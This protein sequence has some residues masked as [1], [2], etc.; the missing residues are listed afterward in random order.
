MKK[1]IYLTA[2]LLSML[3]CAKFANAQNEGP[4]TG[5]NLNVGSENVIDDNVI[6]GNAI[7]NNNRLHTGNTF[8]FG[9]YNSID[10]FHSTNSLVFG[11]RNTLTGSNTSVFGIENLV[12]T[13]LGFVVGQNVETTAS[14]NAFVFGTGI[15]SENRL[16]NALECSFMVGFNSTR[17]TFLVYGPRNVGDV[18][19]MTGKIAIGDVSGDELRDTD[20]KMI[21]RSDEGEDAG[22]ILEPKQP[23]TNGTFIRLHDGNHGISVGTNGEMCISSGAENNKLPLTLNG[24]VGINT[25]NDLTNYQYALTVDG[26]ILTD[27]VLI[28]SVDE[29]YDAVF[30]DNY[31]LMPLNELK[32]FVAAHHHLPEV[33]AESKVM[34]EGYDMGEM[35]G[36]LLKKIEELTLYTIRLQEQIECQ[37]KELELQQKEIEELKAK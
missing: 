32:D 19:D 29:W 13:Q 34:E 35:Q 28:K 36:L 37:Q 27:R 10:G 18:N 6:C 11:T 26:G 3:L 7:G 2:A 9:S 5:S 12:H 33:P 1:S 22:I 20:A 15:N 21:I 16:L 31:R 17:P 23:E 24:K 30:T 8:A 14:E 4:V 25:T